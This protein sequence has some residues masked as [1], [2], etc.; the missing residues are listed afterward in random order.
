MQLIAIGWPLMVGN[1]SVGI[2][3]CGVFLRSGTILPSRIRAVAGIAS[4]V[5][6]RCIFPFPYPA[7]QIG[8]RGQHRSLA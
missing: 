4:A 7:R 6:L 8:P 3:A 1:M 5:A 2:V